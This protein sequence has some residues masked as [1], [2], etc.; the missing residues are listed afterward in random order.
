MF[1]ESQRN[2]M[3]LEAES[4][5]KHRAQQ[6]RHEERILAMMMGFIQSST[7]T[8]PS[9]HPPYQEPQPSQAPCHFFPPNYSQALPNSF[10]YSD[11]DKDN[12]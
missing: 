5:E 9:Y 8:R 6:Q 7:N 3:L 11:S 10:P 12:N 1:T 4:E 2:L